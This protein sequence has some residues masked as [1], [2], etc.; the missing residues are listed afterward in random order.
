VVAA[1]VVAAALAAAAGSA[2]N[3]T[4]CYLRMIF[5]ENRYTLFLIMRYAISFA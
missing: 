5:S 1:L 3:R 2:A 4:T